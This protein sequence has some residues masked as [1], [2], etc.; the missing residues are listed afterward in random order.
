MP[1]LLIYSETILKENT[2]K[3]LN[4]E[5]SLFFK[6]INEMEINSF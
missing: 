4:K 5:N 3:G 2:F 1:M 6:D